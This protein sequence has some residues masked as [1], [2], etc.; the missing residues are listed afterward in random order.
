MAASGL[1]RCGAPVA[2]HTSSTG[3]VPG[4]PGVTDNG[5]IVVEVV[6]AG[7]AI[8]AGA[9]DAAVLGAVVG[10][11]PAPT[12]LDAWA[13]PQPAA[14]AALNRIAGIHRRITPDRSDK[15]GTAPTIPLKP[16]P[17]SCSHAPRRSHLADV[18]LTGAPPTRPPPSSLAPP[19][20]C[21]PSRS[22]P[23]YRRRRRYAL[24]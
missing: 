18:P 16:G 10:V 15:A 7:A 1:L 3:T 23:A 5:Q 20:D 21:Q 12:V 24:L 9:A 13:D 14:T 4:V 8:D 17:G 2:E 11:V 6:G 22:G 19:S